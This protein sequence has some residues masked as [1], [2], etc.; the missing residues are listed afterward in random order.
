MITDVFVRCLE[1]GHFDELTELYA[2]D[3]LLDTHLPYWRT[4]SESPSEIVATITKWFPNQ[5]RVS[6]QRTESGPTYEL[7][8]FERTWTHSDGI[9][10]VAR[11]LHVIDIADAQI[12]RQTVFCAGMWSPETVAKMAAA[13]SVTIP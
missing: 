9:E 12:T 8:Q 6:V 1:S 7:L 4:Q 3:A 2:D 10:Y 5:G 13:G 11:Q